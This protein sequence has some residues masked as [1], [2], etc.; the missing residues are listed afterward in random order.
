[1]NSKPL[2]L[3]Y[4]SVMEEELSGYCETY[5]RALEIIGRRWT[6]AIVRAL[7]SGHTRFSEITET[8]PG[9]SDRLL[10]ERLKELEEEGIV[11]RRVTTCRPVRVDYE[12]TD[13]GG[14][15]LPVVQSVESWA[16]AWTA[17]T[18]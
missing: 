14:A 4:Y 1:M 17:R 8:I 18:R 15:L 7:M 3:G 13:L 11:R 2:I 6:G 10:S 16:E 12:L 9:L 5:T